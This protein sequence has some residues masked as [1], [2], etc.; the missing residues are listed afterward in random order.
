MWW[1]KPVI[2]APGRQKQAGLYE[3][4]TSLAYRAE[5]QD[6]RRYMERGGEEKGITLSSRDFPEL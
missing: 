3:F 4:K 1:S 6:S 5:F 2:P